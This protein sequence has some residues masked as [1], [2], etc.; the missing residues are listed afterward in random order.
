MKRLGIFIVALIAVATFSCSFG[1][2]T[3]ATLDNATYL[4]RHEVLAL[5]H[6]ED[7]HE[8]TPE[9]LQKQV[10]NFLV[11][12]AASRSATSSVST[13]SSVQKFDAVIENGFSTTTSNNRAA[14]AIQEAS[15]IPFYL[16][17][18][19]NAEENTSGYAMTCGDSRFPGVFA[20]V[21]NGEFNSDN[22]FTD[23]FYSNLVGYILETIDIY[24]NVTDEDIE[25]AQEKSKKLD[26]RGAT[27]VENGYTV[28][29]AH[30]KPLTYRTN[31][32]QTDPYWD[33]V[34]SIKGK[35]LSAPVNQK[36]YVGC[37]ATAVAQIMAYHSV[38][39]AL[40][41]PTNTNTVG[42]P[43]WPAT[44]INGK[45]SFLDPYTNTTISFAN[46]NYND[47]QYM[48]SSKNLYNLNNTAKMKIGLLMY[49]IGINVK[50]DYD[51]EGSGAYSEDVVTGITKM[52]YKKPSLVKYQLT[53]IKT[54]I[55]DCKP[56]Y[57]AGFAKRKTTY[58]WYDIFKVTPI[59]EYDDGHAWVIDNYRT[60]TAGSQV[61]E[62]VHCNLGWTSNY[63]VYKTNNV[64]G[65]ENG[66]YLSGIFDT[67]SDNF[68]YEQKI[69]PNITPTN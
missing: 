2:E 3:E 56:V 45:T 48:T 38:Q 65:N 6:L 52:G 23:V 44:T 60:E 32:G 12:N 10:T 19:S 64:G 54:S 42:I 46:I 39:K 58:A 5:Q 36:V 37:V 49:E 13:I 61:R 41:T 27:W 8:V 43:A 4:E 68:K 35:P 11:D 9:V 7:S 53:T 15:E 31:W 28:Y 20:V 69:I 22:P 16:F 18:I 63:G 51:Q 59:Y 40:Q 50:M 1:A 62:Y 47:W 67:G 17:G 33:V 66:W 29:Q 57:I 24:N 30:E 26:F 14:D 55:E 25:A 34:N 21:E